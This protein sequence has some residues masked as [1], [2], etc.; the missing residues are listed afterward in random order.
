MEKKQFVDGLSVRPPNPKA[1]PFVK[2]SISF[3]RVKLLEWLSNRQEEYVNIDIKE[4]KSGKW[5]GEVNE[6]KKDQSRVQGGEWEGRSMAYESLKATGDAG[7]A[8]PD[9]ESLPF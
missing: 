2:A 9:I 6:W 5:Y 4:A 1:P 8:D 3:N 7:Q